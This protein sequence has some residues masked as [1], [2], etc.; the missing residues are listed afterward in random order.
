[1]GEN[2]LYDNIDDNSIS[3]R[4]YNI[5]FLNGKIIESFQSSTVV[6]SIGLDYDKYKYLLQQ[7]QID[8]YE[9]YIK[10]QL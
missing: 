1:M 8:D 10:E 4:T 2:N 5:D 9:K 7:W 6:G 3:V